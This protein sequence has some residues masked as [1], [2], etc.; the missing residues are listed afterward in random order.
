MVLNFDKPIKRQE[1]S[2]II[3]PDVLGEWSFEDSLVKNHLFRTLVFTPAIAFEPDTEYRVD[4]SNIVNTFG[5]TISIN[6]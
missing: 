2:H 3:T 1:V 6:D 4:L 5:N